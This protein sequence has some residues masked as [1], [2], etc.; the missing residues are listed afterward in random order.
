MAD[1]V[2]CQQ[3]MEQ[4][5]RYTPKSP[6]SRIRGIVGSIGCS[7]S[8]ASQ[9]LGW[10]V[11]THNRCSQARDV[12]DDA[13]MCEELQSNLCTQGVAKVLTRMARWDRMMLSHSLGSARP[14]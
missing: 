9:P 3:K 1:M 8:F 7:N 2:V 13:S 5:D 4:N 12:F 11:G 14:G 10:I 6:I